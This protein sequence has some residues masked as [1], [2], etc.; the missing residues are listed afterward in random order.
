MVAIW[1]FVAPARTFELRIGTAVAVTGLLSLGLAVSEYV[2]LH[3]RARDPQPT[4][5]ALGS[6]STRPVL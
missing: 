1:L 2:L 4:G 5:S 3:R 6:N